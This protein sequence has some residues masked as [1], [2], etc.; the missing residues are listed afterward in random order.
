M[1][2]IRLTDPPVSSRPNPQVMQVPN[3]RPLTD[4]QRTTLD[5]AR[6]DLDEARAAD[7]AALSAASLIFLVERL[8]GRLDEVLAVL[9]NLDD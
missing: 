7:L 6:R 2:V 1:H 4:A 8:R 5:F 9:D 3:D